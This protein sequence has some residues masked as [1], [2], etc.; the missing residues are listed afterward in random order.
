MANAEQ[1]GNIDNTLNI[2]NLQLNG[3]GKE[4]QLI[5]FTV[6][7]EEFGLNVLQVQE[8]IRYVKPTKIPHAPPFMEGV[9]DFRGDVIPVINMRERF[10]IRDA[11]NK[12]TSVIIVIENAGRIFGLTVDVVSD[13]LSLPQDKIQQRIEFTGEDKTKY[14]QA[15]GKLDERLI[16]IL[17]L[18]KIID[19]NE[20]K[21]LDEMVLSL[22]ENQV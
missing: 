8:I 9:I 3:A 12:E 10:G 4:E 2:M 21:K 19:F 22:K 15:M 18:D 11:D 17:D 14:L 6:G 7:D 1:T 5:V 16:L 13:L 20:E